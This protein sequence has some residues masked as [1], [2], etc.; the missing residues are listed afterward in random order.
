MRRVALEQL[1]IIPERQGEKK[2]RCRLPN[3]SVADY[4]KCMGA[5]EGQGGE[6][7]G[8]GGFIQNVINENMYF[9][10]HANLG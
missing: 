5:S 9:H 8:G 4:R 3:S 6:V 1:V 2:L 10:L 7:S